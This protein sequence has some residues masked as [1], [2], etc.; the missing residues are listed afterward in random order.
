MRFKT[1]IIWPQNAFLVLISFLHAFE[2]L[3]PLLKWLFSCSL[4]CP[5]REFFLTHPSKQMS[6]VT[7]S[8]SP[9]LNSSGR[10]IFSS[11]IPQHLVHTGWQ[12]LCHI[13]LPPLSPPWFTCLWILVLTVWSGDQQH[14]CL[15]EL[16]E[17]QNL[18]PCPRNCIVTKFRV[19]PLQVKIWEITLWNSVPTK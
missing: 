16:S 5:F 4:P 14:W 8:G 19:T 1:L 12:V 17:M 10:F 15:L 18:R 7:S 13:L 6:H 9:S 2:L 11:T 3:F